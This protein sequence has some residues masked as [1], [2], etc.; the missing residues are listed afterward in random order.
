MLPSWIELQTNQKALSS[1]YMQIVKHVAKYLGMSTQSFLLLS[2][3]FID[4]L[5][6]LVKVSRYACQLFLVLSKYIKMLFIQC[7]L[8]VSCFAIPAMVIGTIISIGKS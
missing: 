4:L 3:L 6:F 5:L 8:K 1:Q 2:Y 7:I